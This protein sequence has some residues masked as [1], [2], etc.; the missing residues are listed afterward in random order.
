MSRRTIVMVNRCRANH[1]NLAESLARIGIINDP[2]CS[3]TYETQD[4]NHV[5]WQCPLHNE[6]REKLIINLKKINLQ[7]PL[8]INVLI[9][10][11]N[12]KA[13]KY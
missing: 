8:N 13:C 9:A 12:I 1:Y 4:L 6:N 5:V 7:L 10:K 11:P 3:C 2:S